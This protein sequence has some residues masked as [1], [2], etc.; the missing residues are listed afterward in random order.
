MFKDKKFGILGL[1]RSGIAAAIKILQHNGTVFIS[2]KNPAAK[3]NIPEELLKFNPT[4][5]FGEHSDKIL[6]CET[7]IVSPGI[8]SDINILQ[9][10]VAMG[11]PVISEIEFAYSIKN[12]DSKI[13]AVTGSNGKSTTV[14]LIAHFLSNAGYNTILAGNIGKPFTSFPIEKPG[15]DFI[16]LELSS[17]QLELVYQ[18]KPIVA[19]LLNITPDHLDRHLTIENYISKKLNIFARQ[20]DSDIAVLNIDDPLVMNNTSK[21]TAHKRFFSTTNSS[22]SDTVLRDN[23]AIVCG[24]EIDISKIQLQGIHNRSNILAAILSVVDFIDDDKLIG[25]SL[26]SFRP[27]PNRLETVSVI[28]DVTFINDSKATNCDSVKYALSAF[29]K[30]IHII[31][32]GYDKGEDYTQLLPYLKNNVRSIHLIGDTANKIKKD[33]SELEQNISIHSTLQQAVISAFDCAQKNEI[34]LL[35]PACASYGMFKD[36]EHRGEVFRNIVKELANDKKIS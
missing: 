17:F 27:L 12:N 31:M 30:P 1:A 7:I 20:I 34:I 3:N 4:I 6:E 15:I 14:S 18:F 16:V 5:E 8:P 11:I 28:N 35:S 2:E 36:Y 13:I 24:R 26:S 29:D 10:A 25:E 23:T 9:K 32:G 33:F 19:V 21:L 22:D